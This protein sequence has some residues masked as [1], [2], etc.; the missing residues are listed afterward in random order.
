MT[1]APETILYP[2]RL[3]RTMDPTRPTGEA[4]VIRGDRI[5]GVGTRDEL[6]AYRPDRVDERYADAVLLPGFVEAH[7]HASSGGVWADTYVGRFD[8]TDPD[9]RVWTGCA[10]LEQVI[11]RMREAEAGMADPEAALRAWGFDPLYFPGEEFDRRHLDQVSRQRKIYLGHTSG[12][13]GIANSALL[14]VGGVDRDCAVVGVVKDADGEPT[15]ELQEFAAMGLVR[16]FVGSLMGALTPETLRA[17]AQDGVNQ[18]ATTLTDLGSTALVQPDGEQ[19]YLDTVDADFAARLS[20]FHFGSAGATSAP[21][22]QAVQRLLELREKST[23]N[24]RFGH[25]KLM[26][27]GS[28]QGFTAR[29]LSPGYLGGQANGIW[30]MSPHEFAEALG[31]FHE[32]GLLVHVHCNGDQST[33]LFLDT[34]EQVLIDHPRPDHRHT[35][36]HSQMS[37]RA[38]YRRM[39]AL[40]MGANI[41]AN[42]TWTWGD[43]HAEFTVGPDKASRMNAARTA[44]DSGVPISLH[45]D[46]PV[47]PLGPLKTV[48]HAVTR[49]TPSGQV[50]G[51]QERITVDEALTAV[52]LGGAYLLKMDHEV[53]SLE[54]G[55]L[56]DL[57]VLAQDPCAVPADEIGQI[58][59]LGTVVGGRH[60]ASAAVA[61][62]SLVG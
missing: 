26:L 18:G 37:T 13:V 10:T 21:P 19:V 51:A 28:I 17:F 56:A 20:V 42:H 22:A 27:D 32:A 24:V 55:K 60:H 36:T 11:E 8:R 2:A 38:Q 15:G 31:T 5:V 53:G 7:S 23:S 30:A 43:Q 61:A 16:E 48:Q 39:A 50:L 4:I 41:F 29:L 34:L 47:T 52:T 12:H 9:G 57:A 3:V 6:Q 44:I 54:P 40:G 49:K 62:A 58:R 33:Q 46:T 35:A 1:E 25:V 59:V 45:C 14:D